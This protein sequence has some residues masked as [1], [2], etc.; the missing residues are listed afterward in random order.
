MR[1]VDLILKTRRGEP[2]TT[3]E[4]DWLISGF[5]DGTVTD[6]QAAAWAMAVCF[7]GLSRRETADLTMAMVRSG[8]QLAWPELPGRTVDKHSTG[9]VGDK[10]T[11]V[12][13]PLVAAA[14]VPLVKMS[15]RG[16]GHTGGTL[17]KL[18]AVPGLTTSLSRDAMLAQV[19]EI[20][21]VIASQT[22]RLVP[23]D[24]A[25]YALRDVTGTVDSLPLMASSIMSKKIA[26]GADAIVLDVKVGSG[27][28]LPDEEQAIALAETMVGIGHEL[29]RET[30]ALLTQMDEPL[31]F[32]VGN[33]IEVNEAAA[34]L[35]GEG[36]ADLTELALALSSELLV[37]AGAADTI[38]EAR[39]QLTGLLTSGAAYERFLALVRSQGG[40]AEAV[41]RGLPLAPHVIDVP[42][43]TAGFVSRID[44]RSVGEAAVMLGAGR[45]RKED[46]VDPAVGLEL[47]KKIGD[48]VA[49]GEPVA[50]LY[51]RDAGQA[52]PVVRRMQQ[53]YTVAAARPPA[54]PLLLA[55]LDTHGLTR[56]T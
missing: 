36:P 34:A 22:A 30:V 54:L 15:G 55:R 53:A 40:D 27:A 49:A 10:T 23:A 42:A 2:L 32:A 38:D 45:S 20:G 21:C 33:A 25:L 24:A 11:L 46:A 47:L 41:A 35:R 9:G 16:L 37:L 17:D 7:Q 52:A 39:V 8:D 29:G 19:Q 56:F 13:A 43:E 1:A 44:A 14:G 31:G 26:A 3:A 48:A 28:F 50:R 51:V 5:A 4:M 6:Y 12:V 18:E